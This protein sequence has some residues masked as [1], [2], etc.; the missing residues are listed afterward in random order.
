MQ[1][2][3]QTG[4]Q[5]QAVMYFQEPKLIRQKHDGV[6]PQA[7]NDILVTCHKSKRG[8]GNRRGRQGPR[9]MWASEAPFKSGCKQ[10]QRCKY[11]SDCAAA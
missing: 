5:I 9:R 1:T 11:R 4:Q 3:Q 8:R 2:S 6:A 7:T 10:C